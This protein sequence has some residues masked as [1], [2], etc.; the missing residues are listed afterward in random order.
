MAQYKVVTD[1]LTGFGAEITSLGNFRSVR[2]FPPEAAAL[3]WIMNS[4]QERSNLPNRFSPK[5]SSDY[6]R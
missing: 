6:T 3:A 4:R 5:S 2:G 1:G